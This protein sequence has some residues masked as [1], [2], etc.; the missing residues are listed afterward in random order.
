MMIAVAWVYNRAFRRAEPRSLGC[1]RVCLRTGRRLGLIVN[2]VAGVGGKVGL[3]G[4][5]G[6]AIQRRALALGAVR[7]APRRAELALAR[8]ARLREH[9][10]IVTCPGEMGENEARACGFEPLVLE[11]VGDAVGAP[12]RRGAELAPDCPTMRRRRRPTIPWR[13]R[14]LC[15]TG[16]STCCCSP[17]ATAPLAT[18]AGR[19]APA[20]SSSSSACRP[21]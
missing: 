7:E 6:V 11:G 18:S 4:S 9:I 17:A 3:K 15:V 8:L 10:E 21:A 1:G 5:D 12:G 13:R 16:V 2:P 19:S 20:P 14:A